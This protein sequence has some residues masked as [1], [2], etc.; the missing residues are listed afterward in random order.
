MRLVRNAG[1]G[2]R[3]RA[4][5]NLTVVSARRH[6]RAR[7]TKYT[8]TEGRPKSS[9]TEQS[10][11]RKI[12]A[13][14]PGTFCRRAF[15]LRSHKS[16]SWHFFHVWQ[17]HQ[18][19]QQPDWHEPWSALI[20]IYSF[21]FL[22][23]DFFWFE[24]RERNRAIAFE[25][26]NFM[27]RCRCEKAVYAPSWSRRGYSHS[28]DIF[29]KMKALESG[30]VVARAQLK[31]ENSER[32][33]TWWKGCQRTEISSKRERLSVTQK[34]CFR[35]FLDAARLSIL[36]LLPSR[37]QTFLWHT[38]QETVKNIS[39]LKSIIDRPD[40]VIIENIGSCIFKLVDW[41]INGLSQL[42]RWIPIKI[43]GLESTQIWD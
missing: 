31:T 8:G 24:C 43:R 30:S 12:L 20:F 37:K 19:W 7:M 15:C 17:I 1:D 42:T 2:T 11:F 36:E 18:I 16:L 40:P 23:F 34:I 22:L 6:T 14:R 38:D 9:V 3:K 28:R 35:K 33:P 29:M 5:L 32:E 21:H 4:Q 27:F 26:R 39:N 25:R 10:R 13:V 41:T